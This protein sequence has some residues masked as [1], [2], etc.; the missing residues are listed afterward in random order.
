[1]L[2]VHC[3]LAATRCPD[4]KQGPSFSEDLSKKMKQ[5][6]EGAG[7]GGTESSVVVCVCCVC[8]FAQEC[9]SVCPWMMLFTGNGQE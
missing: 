7:R 2:N 8:V 4:D 9:E 3:L 1:M 6:E 5:E